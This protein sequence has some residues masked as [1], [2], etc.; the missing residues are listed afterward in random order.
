MYSEKQFR[1]CAAWAGD[2]LAEDEPHNA[3]TS[4]PLPFPSFPK[5]ANEWGYAGFR[6]QGPNRAFP[7]QEAT[8]YEE[9]MNQSGD[10]PFPV[11]TVH[12]TV[13]DGL[14][15]AISFIAHKGLAGIKGFRLKQLSRIQQRANA[16]IP[17]LRKPR[18]TVERPREPSRARLHAPPLEELLEVNG[19]A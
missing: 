6:Y 14:Q 9:H 18:P 11:N 16:L 5:T 15:G 19:A 8:S 13:P 2:E 1:R 7:L 4:D 10:P 17:T 3:T 12:H